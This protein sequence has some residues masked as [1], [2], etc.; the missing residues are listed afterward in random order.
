M[1]KLSIISILWMICF[2]SFA[3]IL[4]PQVIAASG[5]Y[6]AGASGSL[7]WTLGETM[8]ETYSGGGYMLTQGFQQPISVAVSGINLNLLAYLEGPFSSGQMNNTLYSSGYIPLNQ[9][10]NTAPWNYDGTEA[11]AAI[12]NSNVVDWVLLELRDAPSAALATASTV[13]AR[14]A[15]FLLRNGT[16]VG[17]N[18]SS[19]LSF[20]IVPQYGLFAVVRHRNHIAVMSASALVVSGGV[21]TYNFSTDAL[22]AYGGSLAHKQLASGIWGLVAADGNA[23]NQVSNLDKNNVWIPQSGSSGYRSGDFNLDGQV[24][25]IDKNVVWKPNSG[26]GGQVPD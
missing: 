22:R 6:N 25:N 12:P 24:N 8:V 2:S 4:S 18:G 5:S 7:S 11:V 20:S 15:A 19:N 13:V 17:L 16:V 3:Q 23:D 26:R 1:K 14:Q 10:Y 9:P 21:Y